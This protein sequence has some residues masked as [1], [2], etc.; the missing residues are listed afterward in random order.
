[1]YVLYNS[2]QHKSNIL[3]LG[4]T[5]EGNDCVAISVFPFFQI[6]NNKF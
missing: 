2:A 1:M 4:N 5:E 6:V 3:S